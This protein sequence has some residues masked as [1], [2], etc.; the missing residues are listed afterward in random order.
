MTRLVTDTEGAIRVRLTSAGAWYVKAVH[1]RE[2]A[3]AEANYESRWSTM[4][5][6]VR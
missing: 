1:M 2:V 5:W 4:T 3:D 6:G